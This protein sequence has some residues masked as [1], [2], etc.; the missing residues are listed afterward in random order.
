MKLYTIWFGICYGLKMFWKQ[1][2]LSV[3]LNVIFEKLVLFKR[4]AA[5]MML[6]A[7][8]FNLK[9]CYSLFWMKSEMKILY[10]L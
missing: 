4:M 3:K 9:I 2:M 5:V 7:F 8:L 6:N 1:K 10:L